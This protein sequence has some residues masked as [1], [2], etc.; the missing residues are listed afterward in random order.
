MGTANR[1]TMARTPINMKTGIDGALALIEEVKAM[2]MKMMAAE[3]KKAAPPDALPLL[4][5]SFF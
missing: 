4:P 2:L 3:V 5:P 1:G